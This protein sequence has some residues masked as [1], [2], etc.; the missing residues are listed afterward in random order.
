MESKT[1]ALQRV[2]QFLKQEKSRRMFER[3]QTIRL[4]LL[5]HDYSQI[6]TSI[7]RSE[8]T[9][10]NIFAPTGSMDWMVCR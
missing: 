5:G 9:V 2:E 7:G 6:A 8:Y 4:Y 3:Y 1:E 10:K